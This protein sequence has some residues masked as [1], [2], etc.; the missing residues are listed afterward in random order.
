[1]DRVVLQFSVSD[2]GIGIT[3]AQQALLFQPFFQAD[4]S[5]TRRYGGTGLGLSIS[6]RLVELMGGQIAIT[7]KAGAGSTFEFTVACG[8][9]ARSSPRQAPLSSHMSDK[10]VLVVDDSADY[11]MLSRARLEEFSMRT[12]LADS[13]RAAIEALVDAE[14]AGD[15]FDLVMLDWKMPIMDGF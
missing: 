10:R 5:T 11:R 4:A 14:R 2:T 7:S 6:R 3:P 9:A 12:S 13:G 15:P 8:R 1:P